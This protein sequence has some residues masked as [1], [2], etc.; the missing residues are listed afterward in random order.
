[1]NLIGFYGVRCLQHMLDKLSDAETVK[2]I[3][4]RD[5][6]TFFDG[7]ASCKHF[8]D[9]PF[10]KKVS[11]Q[12]PYFA[13]NLEQMI[14]NHLYNK[15]FSNNYAGIMRS[16]TKLQLVPLEF[17][18]AQYD[19]ILSLDEKGLIS[20]KDDTFLILLYAGLVKSIP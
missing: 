15:E 5:L 3:K 7:L 2:T 9:D 17:F 6:N 11:S 16:I 4:L 13:K 14:L 8:E 12:H 1:M 18:D 10:L 20:E 19:F